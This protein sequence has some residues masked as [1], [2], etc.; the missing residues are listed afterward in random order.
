MERATPGSGILMSSWLREG[1]AEGKGPFGIFPKGPIRKALARKEISYD[2][3]LEA[4][5]QI[6]RQ[7]RNMPEIE[8]LGAQ[9][10]PRLLSY[11]ICIA[12]EL[13]KWARKAVRTGDKKELRWLIDNPHINEEIRGLQKTL[14]NLEGDYAEARR[15][16]EI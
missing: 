12:K 10:F 8:L 5:E 14:E 15:R 3:V 4:F 1:V 13:L 16:G 9:Y 11:P 2:E 6:E 7:L